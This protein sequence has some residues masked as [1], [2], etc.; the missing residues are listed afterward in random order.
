MEADLFRMSEATV[1]MLKSSSAKPKAGSVGRLVTN[2]YVLNMAMAVYQISVI[3]WF[4]V[5]C[6]L[7][8]TTSRM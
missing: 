4:L 2:A 3:D 7:S 5:S 6:E 1:T 8:T